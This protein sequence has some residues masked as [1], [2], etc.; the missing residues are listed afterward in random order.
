MPP[1]SEQPATAMLLP[2]HPCKTVCCVRTALQPPLEGPHRTDGKCPG[3]AEAPD[4]APQPPHRTAQHSTHLLWAA[5]DVG[6]KLRGHKVQAILAVAVGVDVV[7]PSHAVGVACALV[8]T[9]LESVCMGVARQRL[10][11]C[12]GGGRAPDAH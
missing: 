2:G 6:V 8:Q 1:D 11:S 7:H 3:A 4:R 12:Q 10:L 9:V 5:D